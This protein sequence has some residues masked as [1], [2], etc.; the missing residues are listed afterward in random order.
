MM[1]RGDIDYN[2]LLQSIQ[3]LSGNRIETGWG[4]A[5]CNK[6]PSRDEQR[7]QRPATAYAAGVSMGMST[8]AKR[9]KSPRKNKYAFRPG[10]PKRGK[11][12]PRRPQTTPGYMI[13][14][15]PLTAT[16]GKER[17]SPRRSANGLFKSPGDLLPNLDSLADFLPSESSEFMK[18]SSSAI[19]S[20]ECVT[21]FASLRSSLESNAS[22]S[23]SDA[24]ATP[25]S[26]DMFGLKHKGVKIEL[27]E[28][29][30][31][32]ISHLQRK[33]VPREKK[34]LTLTMKKL[35]SVERA[36][37]RSIAECA[38]DAS[39]KHA[40]TFL[41]TILG[42]LEMSF[43]A[44]FL[45]VELSQR[46]TSELQRRAVRSKALTNRNIMKAKHGSSFLDVTS[47]AEEDSDTEADED[48]K[49]KKVIVQELSK[50]IQSL[51]FQLSAKEKYWKSRVSALN[52]RLSY[53]QPVDHSWSASEAGSFF[54]KVDQVEDALS[55]FESAQAERVSML[56]QMSLSV[57]GMRRAAAASRTS[58]DAS[59]QTDI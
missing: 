8:S 44:A 48:A 47:L 1:K 49:Q 21:E 43:R 57:E 45:C 33:S 50:E 42:I 20:L 27:D 6:Y 17:K 7:R 25:E 9:R 26:C 18:E 36:V 38:A 12:S 16:Q 34:L 41:V 22:L 11:T 39:N 24:I 3:L 35:L 40:R 51:R 52:V 46:S 31:S 37:L 58:A 54:Q 56:A 32:L 30:V 13:H 10:S 53:H 4:G 29:L 2:R 55:A 59:C 5:R 28:V 15:R 23:I 14:Q 19:K